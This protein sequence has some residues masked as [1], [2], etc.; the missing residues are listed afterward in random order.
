MAVHGS[1]LLRVAQRYEGIHVLRRLVLLTIA[2][3]SLTG[4]GLSPAWAIM[5]V[6]GTGEPVYTKGTTNTHW[7]RAQ[8]NGFEG[9]RVAVTYFANNV[10]VYNETTVNLGVPSNNVL[11]VNW[12]GLP[13]NA[14]NTLQSGST[15]G[16]CGAG[17]DYYAYLTSWVPELSG[18]SSCGA[19][20]L[21]NKRTNTT[22]DN[23]KPT[24]V[25]SV[26]GTDTFTKNP[27]VN[28]RLDYQ[29]S[30][31]PPWPATYVCVRTAATSPNPATACNGVTYQY[32][33][34]CSNRGSGLGLANF[35]TCTF[36]A[37]ADAPDG[38]ITFCGV[39]ADSAIPDNAAGADQFSG[40]T[41]SNANLSDPGC[42]YVNLDRT[43][44]QVGISGGAA[45][46]FVGDLLSFSASASDAG[47][48]ANGQY[49]WT[50]GDNTPNGNGVNASHTFTQ[51]GTF[52]VT[53]ATADGAGNPGTASR[54]VVVSAKPAP[55][56]GGGGAGGSGGAGGAGGPSTGGGTTTGGGGT[57]TPP[58]ST[59]E[60]AKQV[61]AT[62]GAPGVT[63][64]TSAG[65]LDVLTAKKV[66][67]T[68]KLKALPMAL[69]AETAGKAQFALVRG[70][71]IA[72]QGG[73]TI[74]KPGTLGFRLKLP[75][76]L[77]AGSYSLRITFTATGA[78]KASVKTIRITFTAAKKKKKPRRSTAQ[79]A[80]AA[81]RVS[82]G[83]PAS[84]AVGARP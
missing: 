12:T 47:S 42:G 19:G 61:G 83:V 52:Q 8:S 79:A 1:S 82:A 74:T 25:A 13:G 55:P 66:K 7:L 30:I 68:T 75:K 24:V 59:Q 77:K 67:I 17:Q 73:I 16:V 6:E 65:G 41:S 9:F 5:N 70:G 18:Q 2:V 53:V 81:P 40:F 31:S 20:I 80:S 84:P 22:I 27:Q 10:S 69:T 37:P 56:G 45:T 4:L 60:I 46:A 32:E 72:A 14:Y 54:T 36:T 58:P 29:D 28:L 78:S 3:T 48:G 50:W 23:S 33:P 38:P 34:L 51:A 11:N 21:T 63:Q 62:G 49:A 44:P 26:N 15:Y 76:K 35:A 71:R 64:T 57:V 39:A 43:A